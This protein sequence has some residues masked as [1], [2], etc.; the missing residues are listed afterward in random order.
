[1]T[2]IVKKNHEIVLILNNF[3][4]K[5]FHVFFDNLSQKSQFS[6]SSK[7]KRKLLKKVEGVEA[8]AHTMQKFNSE[9]LKCIRFEY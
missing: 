8:L 9:K 3:L 4:E 6:N 7:N 2:I 5:L 1:M